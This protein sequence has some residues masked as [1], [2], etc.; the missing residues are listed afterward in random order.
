MNIF[1]VTK[2][3]TI[4]FNYDISCVNC[5]QLHKH[6]KRSA[7]I[8]RKKRFGYGV[9]DIELAKNSN[10]PLNETFK[11]T[12]QWTLIAKRLK[13]LVGYGITTLPF[14]IDVEHRDQFDTN[15]VLVR[16]N[17]GF[18]N[19]GTSRLGD[20]R[21]SGIKWKSN[22]QIKCSFDHMNGRFM[23]T[24]LS[25]NDSKCAVIEQDISEGK[26]FYPFVAF[27]DPSEIANGDQIE[28]YF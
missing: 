21:H 23:M 13:G 15:T 17:S 7:M 10:K 1:D 25:A 18:I 14:V 3:S 12:T 6:K 5:N 20:A 9:L 2:I 4:E 24:K 22:D 8:T 16:N 11:K 27:S 26:T 28:I 19:G